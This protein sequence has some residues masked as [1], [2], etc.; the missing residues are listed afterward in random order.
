METVTA[1]V[2]KMVRAVKNKLNGDD[3][4]AK[5]RSMAQRRDEIDLK[6]KS[7]LDACKAIEAE[8]ATAQAQ[9]DANPTPAGVG[10]LIMIRLRS[11]EAT[12]IF[13]ALDQR[14]RHGLANREFLSEFKTE[15][16]G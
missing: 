8:V 10:E 2:G 12:E 1:P 7:V 11:R 3:A 6:F 16:R 5:L 4:I 15:L 14:L 9:F 13:A